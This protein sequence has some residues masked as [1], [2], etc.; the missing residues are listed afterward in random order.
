MYY[1]EQSTFESETVV[2]HANVTVV[3]TIE[4]HRGAYFRD[5]NLGAPALNPQL[6]CHMWRISTVLA[7]STTSTTART[8]STSFGSIIKDVNVKTLRQNR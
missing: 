2:A 4:V 7:N 8:S 1:D 3:R 6:S 5:D